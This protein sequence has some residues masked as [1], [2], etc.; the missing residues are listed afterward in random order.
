MFPQRQIDTID[1]IENIGLCPSSAQRGGEGGGQ[2]APGHLW[3][4]AEAPQQ[5]LGEGEP[6]PLTAGRPNQIWLRTES[7]Y[8]ILVSNYPI[9]RSVNGKGM[10]KPNLLYSRGRCRSMRIGDHHP[11]VVDDGY[12]PGKR[13]SLSLNGKQLGTLGELPAHQVTGTAWRPQGLGRSR[14]HHGSLSAGEP[15]TWRR[16]SADPMKL[17]QTTSLTEA[18]SWN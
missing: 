8:G 12:H 1:N 10:M 3:C 18:I 5:R 15:R 7:V 16:V 2:S 6:R 17:P 4:W 9:P 14:R 13:R 11:T